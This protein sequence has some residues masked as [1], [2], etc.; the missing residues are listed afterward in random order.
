MGIVLNFDH[1]RSSNAARSAKVSAVKPASRARSV[2]RSKAHHSAGTLSLCHHLETCAG[3]APSSEAHSSRVGQSSTTSRKEAKR[4]VME[5]YLGQIV[6]ERKPKTSHD[7]ENL[8]GQN[9]LMNGP[10]SEREFDEA[11][12]RRTREARIGISGDPRKP[13]FSQT[14]LAEL[15]GTTQGTYKN[16]EIDR[17]LPHYLIPRFC[18]LC[19][20]TVNHMFGV[21]AKAKNAPKAISGPRRGILRPSRTGT[22]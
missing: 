1:S 13:R 11:F 10:L 2:P 4:S 6:L 20:V 17:C 16:Y 22:R 7:T 5:N 8:S 12:I 19:G 15:L 18:Q 3:L 14:D 21:K 9:V